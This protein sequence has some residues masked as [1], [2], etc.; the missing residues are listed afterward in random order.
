VRQGHSRPIL[1]EDGIRAG[2]GDRRQGSSGGWQLV[3]EDQGVECDVTLDAPAMQRSQGFR[4]LGH[5]ESRFGARREMRQAEIHSVGAG[6]DGCV[7]L[8]P[9]TGGTLD[10]G[11]RKGKNHYVQCMPSFERGPR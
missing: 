8:R 1:D 4:Q 5:S 11:L 9:V 10:F 6:F 2:F 7:Q 3:V